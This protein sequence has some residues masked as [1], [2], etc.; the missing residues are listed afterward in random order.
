MCPERSARGPR[1]AAR[2]RPRSNRPDV[3]SVCPPKTRTVQKIQQLRPTCPP[4]RVCAVCARLARRDSQPRGPGS[5]SEPHGRTRTT[6]EGPE[7][8][9]PKPHFFLSSGAFWC[10]WCCRS[11][12]PHRG[13]RR[14]STSS[15]RSLHGIVLMIDGRAA[16]Q[17]L[18][19]EDITARNQTGPGYVLQ[20]LMDFQVQFFFW[21]V[22]DPSKVC[23]LFSRKVFDTSSSRGPFIG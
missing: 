13:A 18:S 8:A 12:F 23:S 7:R 11:H 6:R 17:S 22:V 10:V 20:A 5:S 16:K 4:V 21:G 1:L 14:R 3:I 9:L 2:D 19:S 15:S